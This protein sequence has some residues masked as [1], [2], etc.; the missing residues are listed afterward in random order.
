MPDCLA[1]QAF[2]PIALDSPTHAF[3]GGDP[4]TQPIWL[5]RGH[6][7]HDKRVGI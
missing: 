5:G 7:Q 6:N 4:E 3:P 1:Q 2:G